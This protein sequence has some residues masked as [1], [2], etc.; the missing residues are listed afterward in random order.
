MWSDTLLLAEREHLQRLFAWGG[1]SVLVG[2]ALLAFLAF[3]RLRAP[4]LSHF[5]IQSASWGAIDIALAWWAWQRLRPRDADAAGALERLLWL[6]VG[7]DI[8]YLGVGVTLAL[9]GFLF[10]RRP[11]AVGAGLGVIV[12]GLALLV[13]D[14][15]F[16]STLGRL[17]FHG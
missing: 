1:A 16:I 12:Q 5:A 11:G 7:L 3:R 2:V 13:L 17:A 10:G 15:L 8:G 9:A 6:N 4:L 14:A